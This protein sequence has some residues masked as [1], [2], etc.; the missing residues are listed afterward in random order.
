[1][2]KRKV[3]GYQVV[4]H[5]VDHLP[6]HCHIYIEGRSVEVRLLDLEVRSPPPN[7]LPGKLRKQLSSVQED[8]LKAWDQVKV[9]PPGSNTT[10]W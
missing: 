5:D 3:G 6:P 9:V 1:M 2:W 10:A 7:S 8:M 4:I